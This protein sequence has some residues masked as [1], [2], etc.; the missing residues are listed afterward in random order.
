MTLSLSMRG[1][2]GRIS[3]TVGA[4]VG[5]LQQRFSVTGHHKRV[6]QV[7]SGLTGTLL[8][9]GTDSAARRSHALNDD[10]DFPEEADSERLLE[11][12]AIDLE[13]GNIIRR[14]IAYK[15]LENELAPS[16]EMPLHSSPISLPRVGGCLYRLGQFHVAKIDI[17][18][19]DATDS[20]LWAEAHAIRTLKRVL[21]N[22]R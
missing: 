10:L 13:G 20:K 6:V 5:Q 18:D 15:R 7:G 9:V 3:P 21:E 4:A 17:K 14:R 1:C 12:R 16:S 19:F 8:L 2:T 11:T 22:F